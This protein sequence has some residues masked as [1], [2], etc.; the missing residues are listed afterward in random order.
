MIL[1]G[2]LAEWLADQNAQRATMERV[3]SASAELRELPALQLLARDLEEVR[4]LPGGAEPVLDVARRFLEGAD[5]P[6]Q[7]VAGALIRAASRDVYFRPPLRNASTDI[8]SGLWLFDHPALTLFL[9]LI[10]C[11]ALAEKRR[12]RTGPSSIAFTGQRSVY[13]FLK[14]GG[15]TLAL[16]EAPE[17]RPGFTCAESGRCRLVERRCLADGEILV[18]DG[19]R[20]GFVIERARTD[21]VYVQAITPVGAAPLMAEYDAETREFVGASSTDEASSRIQLMLSLLRTMERTDAAPVFEEMLESPHF[22]ARWQ[23]MRE[24]LALDCELAF[25]HLER[26]ARADPHPEVRAAARETL[27]AFF[28]ADAPPATEDEL[29]PA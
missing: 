18:V 9:G 3:Q 1:E 14:T 24:F 10:R 17:I 7:R 21:V 12:G 29:C 20:H 15:A 2:A 11:E 5:D 13:R 19:R 22:Y 6:L 25:P 26:M 23:A 8:L 16:W 28:G 27:T 4:C